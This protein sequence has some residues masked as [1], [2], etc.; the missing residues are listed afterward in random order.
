MSSS[1]E[2]LIVV[3]LGYVGLPVALALAKHFD[4]VGFDIDQQR[5]DE[6]ARGYDSTGC[7]ATDQLTNSGLRLSS[8][9]AAAFAERT[10]VIV[11]VP[12]PI[13]S[14]KRPD[15]GPLMSA[16]ELVAQHLS[17][18]AVV[19]FESTVYPGVTEEVCIPLLEKRSGLSFGK[20]FSVGY[21]PERINPGDTART[22]DKIT[23]V[24]AARDAA[25]LGR[26]RQVYDSVVHAGTFVAASIRVAEAAK[27]IEN[28]QRDLNV[29]L[30]NELAMIFD[31]L[32][33]R[34]ADVLEAA[35]T[36]WN[37]LPF[38]PG[39]V[40][41]HCIGVDPYYLASKAEA[42]GYHPEILLAGRRLNDG[43]G[44]FV[45]RKAAKLAS[46][47][48]LTLSCARVGIL[49]I[50]FKENVPDQRNS[51]VPDI[52]RELTE[53]GA[54]CLVHDPLAVWALVEQS[55]GL[56]LSTWDDIVDL[57]V[58]IYAVAHA[59]YQGNELSKCV[60]HGGVFIDVKSQLSA[61]SFAHKSV[62]YWSL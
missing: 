54:T 34:T 12:T 1:N 60:R 7:V 4:T 52:V 26:M 11:T 57:D 21:S 3:G 39:L 28:I 56:K 51:R 20:D 43:I 49:G 10:F 32:D 62:E 36:K 8:S 47:R 5:L 13:D 55:Y 41:G 27:A 61:A 44:T 16:T 50:T 59:F 17:P 48:G 53:Y 45:A 25:T 58:V 23:K 29:A 30:L 42:V 37:F 14:Q 18:G 6:L 40:G 9:P 31:M 38:K 19:V 46:R 35:A 33:I 24:V 22:F 15:L 2:R